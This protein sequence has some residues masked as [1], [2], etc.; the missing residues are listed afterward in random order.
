MTENE[1]AEICKK[2]INKKIKIIFNNNNIATG[3][4][5]DFTWAADN[6]PEIASIAIEDKTG[7][8]HGYLQT[9]IESI[10]VLE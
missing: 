6:D 2:C 3:R 7:Q 1:L 9:E 5:F 4:F 8:L 10:E